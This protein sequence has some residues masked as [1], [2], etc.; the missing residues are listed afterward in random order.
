MEQKSKLYQNLLVRPSSKTNPWENNGAGY[1]QA[2]TA[3]QGEDRTKQTMLKHLDD[4]LSIDWGTCVLNLTSNMYGETY[5]A[6]AALAIYQSFAPN[7]KYIISHQLMPGGETVFGL[8]QS[9][10]QYLSPGNYMAVGDKPL[11]T[12]GAT[13]T[14]WPQVNEFLF[15]KCLL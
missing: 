1:R 10:L 2:I 3:S 5:Y 12:Q 8:Q 13:V 14:A 7:N 9:F 4:A 15:P 6:A 11:S